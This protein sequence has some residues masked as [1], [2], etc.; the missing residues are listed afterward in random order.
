MK[1]HHAVRVWLAF[2]VV[3]I[4]LAACGIVHA[5]QISV[6]WDHVTG[7]THYRF[8][9]RS[10]VQEYDRADP[11]RRSPDYEVSAVCG[12]NPQ[13]GDTCGVTIADQ[14][15]IGRRYYVIVAMDDQDE[16][17]NFS[18]EVY[19]TWFPAPNLRR[20]DA[21]GIAASI[22]INIGTDGRVEVAEAP[23]PTDDGPLR[24]EGPDPVHGPEIHPAVARTMLRMDL[25]E[26]FPGGVTDR[27]A[28]RV[29][30]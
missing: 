26:E 24:T 11:E 4:I 6:E 25:K 13:S 15:D 7:A 29:K 8:Y 1:P 20:V 22:T 2:V 16:S 23:D 17:A 21:G 18:N 10:P 27:V 5:G 3:I 28:L 14:P 19:K 9:M 30:D 12:E